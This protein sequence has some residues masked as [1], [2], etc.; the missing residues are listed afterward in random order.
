M[1]YQGLPP[2]DLPILAGPDV[3]LP[4]LLSILEA[5]GRSGSRALENIEQKIH[6]I[7]QNAESAIS[8]YEIANALKM[9]V[10]KRKTCLIRLP[11]GWPED[12]CDFQDPLDYLGSDGGGGVGAGAGAG[13]AGSSGGTVAD[14]AGFSISIAPPHLAH[15]VLA[16][17]R[18]PSFASSNR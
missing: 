11:L 13:G 4:Q 16:L 9:T 15:R 6:P 12:A 8:H 2:V 3:I 14:E 7:T 5:S 10:G 18:S 17:G 1:D